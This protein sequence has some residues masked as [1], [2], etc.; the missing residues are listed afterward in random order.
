MIDGGVNTEGKEL[1]ATNEVEQ[2]QAELETYLEDARVGTPKFMALWDIGDLKY[3][4]ESLLERDPIDKDRTGALLREQFCKNRIDVRRSEIPGYNEAYRKLL[5]FSDTLQ[6]A[7]NNESKK[8]N[9]PHKI[10]T[11]ARNTYWFQL[12]GS[13]SA[14]PVV[15]K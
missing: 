2:R 6:S 5:T 10:P 13:I 15:P 8:P 4:Q 14:K 1:G 12:R 9:S 11:E 3:I 7:Y